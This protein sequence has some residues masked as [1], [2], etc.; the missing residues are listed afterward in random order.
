MGQGAYIAS[1]QRLAM[2]HTLASN[3]AVRHAPFGALTRAI[4]GLRSGRA[5]TDG[6][7]TLKKSGITRPKTVLRLPDLAQAKSAVLNTLS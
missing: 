3:T 7:E 2:I 1:A 5:A 4:I 6:K